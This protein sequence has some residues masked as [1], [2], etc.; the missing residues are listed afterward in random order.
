MIWAIFPFISKTEN[1]F[2]SSFHLENIQ[3]HTHT[4]LEWSHLVQVEEKH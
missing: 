1:N 2:A 4:Q 3:V